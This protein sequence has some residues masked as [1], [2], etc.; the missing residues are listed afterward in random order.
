[1]RIIAGTKKGVKLHSPPDQDSRPITDR[2]KESLFNVLK[3]YCAPEAMAV[4]DVFCGVGSLGLESLSRGADLVTFVDIDSKVLE[5]LEKN[6]K[7]CAFDKDI[8]VIQA[9]AFQV[10]APFVYD[11][12]RY[13]LVFVDPPFK[14]TQHIAPGS[15]F[16]GLMELLPGSME[17]N[18]LVVVRTSRD[19]FLYEN[20]G[21]LEGIERREWGTMAVSIF[22]L[23]D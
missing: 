8:R 10:G 2:V 13:G 5:I 22:R 12:Q 4:A 9:D 20:Y 1:M 7:K 21:D 14:F 19:V 18:G 23:N 3:K 17:S 16:D 11:Q 6:I 15:K